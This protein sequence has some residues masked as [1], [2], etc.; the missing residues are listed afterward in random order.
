MQPGSGDP[1]TAEATTATNDVPNDC[2][3]PYVDNRESDDFG[4]NAS[5]NIQQLVQDCHQQASRALGSRNRRR[6]WSAIEISTLAL[7]HAALGNK[8]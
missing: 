3:I 5:D 7:L 1:I 6:T 4:D 2:Q 8:W